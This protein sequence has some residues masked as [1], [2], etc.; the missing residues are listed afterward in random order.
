ALLWVLILIGRAACIAIAGKVTPPAF[1]RLSSI[2]MAVFLVVIILGSGFSMLLLGTIG[3]G[4]CMAGMY[5]TTIA[6]AS[7]VFKAYPLAMGFFVSLTGIGSVIA[8][9]VVG[10]VAGQLGIRAGLGVLLLPAVLLILFAL[11]NH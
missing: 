5:G 6:N 9:S 1:L 8:P 7:E 11:L 4:L 10:A 3:L 2:G